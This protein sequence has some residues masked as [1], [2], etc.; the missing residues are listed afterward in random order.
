MTPK[1]FGTW[2]EAYYMPYAN[3][4]QR[5]E[6]WDYLKDRSPAYLDALKLVVRNTYSSSKTGKAPDIAIFEQCK[7]QAIALMPEA[8]KLPEP[9]R[10][11]RKPRSVSEIMADIASRARKN[12]QDNIQ[13]KTSRSA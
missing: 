4:V 3:Q 7:T 1:E 8:P 11:Y 5:A 10:V 12:T 13:D 2:V 9:A 6:V